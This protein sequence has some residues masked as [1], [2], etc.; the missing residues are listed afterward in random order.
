MVIL[1]LLRI[2]KIICEFLYYTGVI[3]R[4]YIK[5]KY[6]NVCEKKRCYFIK[7]IWI[8]NINHFE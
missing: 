1:R 7:K 6:A 5:I 8:F 2:L 3:Y 4:V